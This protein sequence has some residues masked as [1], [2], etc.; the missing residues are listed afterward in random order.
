MDDAK[1]RFG[2]RLRTLRLERGLTQEAL[3][4]LSSVDRVFVG[5]LE[6]GVKGPGLE[7]LEKLAQGLGVAPAELLGLRAAPVSRK[8]SLGRWIT[9]LAEEAPPYEVARFKRV[10]RAFFAGKERR[11]RRTRRG[12]RP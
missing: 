1:A 2:K 4:R 10:A 7:T 3:S 5:E 9:A 11:A 8:E 6:R 12:K